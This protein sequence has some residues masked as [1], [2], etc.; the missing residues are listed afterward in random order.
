MATKTQS[1]GAEA[2][3]NT[4]ASLAPDRIVQGRGQVVAVLLGDCST[5]ALL[6]Q[7]KSDL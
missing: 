2:I 5:V 1:Q 4:S 6:Q 7:Q 3:S